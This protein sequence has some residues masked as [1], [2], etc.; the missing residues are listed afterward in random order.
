MNE[1]FIIIMLLKDLEAKLN[2]YRSGS[3]VNIEWERNIESAKAKKLNHKIIKHS[4]GII[5][6]EVNYQNLE[7]VLNQPTSNGEKK[8]SWFEHYTK[9][10]IQSK[11]NPEKKY[12]QAFPV[13]GKKILTYYSIDGKEVDPFQLYSEGLITKAALPTTDSEQLLTFTLSVD[14]IITFG[15]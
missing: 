13:P 2:K 11:K 12:L 9:G 4:K 1:R 10:I 3:F 6:T 14:N 8:E 5:R 15:A 7:R